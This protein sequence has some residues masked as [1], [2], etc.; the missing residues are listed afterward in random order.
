V[1]RRVRELARNREISGLIQQSAIAQ[2]KRERSPHCVR[3]SSAIKERRTILRQAS[4]S[5]TGTNRRT[6]KQCASSGFYKWM[7]AGILRNSECELIGDRSFVKVGLRDGAGTIELRELGV[8][9]VDLQR[10]PTIEVV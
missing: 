7:K 4:R 8:L 2:L 6:K 1:C 3:D 10:T 5:G 9:V